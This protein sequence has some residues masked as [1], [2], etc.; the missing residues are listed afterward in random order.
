LKGIIEEPDIEENTD[1]Q[2][3]YDNQ[4]QQYEPSFRLTSRRRK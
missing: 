3:Q 1:K 2:Q 4:S